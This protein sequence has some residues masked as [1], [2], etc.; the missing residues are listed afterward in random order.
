M[1]FDMI[2]AGA[3]G[4]ERPFHFFWCLGGREWYVV[5]AFSAPHRP[6]CLDPTPRW[7]TA[8]GGIIYATRIPERWMPGTFDLVFNSHQIWHVAAILCAYF[9]YHAIMG[10]V[11]WRLSMDCQLPTSPSST[12]P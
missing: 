3:T 11:R 2:V 1:L 12:P 4:C 5:M 9:F 10:Y 7:C 6:S 8:I